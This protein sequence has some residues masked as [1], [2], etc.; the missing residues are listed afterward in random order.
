MQFAVGGYLLSFSKS[1]IYGG[2]IPKSAAAPRSDLPMLSR[3][4]RMNFPNVLFVFVISKHLFITMFASIFTPVRKSVNYF[5][6]SFQNIFTKNI[7]CLSL[8]SP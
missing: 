6:V 1:D 5:Y 3:L 4:A 8:P 2:A 7:F